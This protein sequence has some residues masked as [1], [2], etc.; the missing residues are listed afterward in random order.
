MPPLVV[1]EGLEVLLLLLGEFLQALLL[2]FLLT[3]YHLHLQ[4]K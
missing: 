3:L 4:E 2:L 1:L